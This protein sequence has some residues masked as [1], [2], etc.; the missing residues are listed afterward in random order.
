MSRSI[1]IGGDKGKTG[2][3]GGGSCHA[4]GDESHAANDVS[5][6]ETGG[7]GSLADIFPP[8]DEG[9]QGSQI[10]QNGQGVFGNRAVSVDNLPD[11]GCRRCKQSNANHSQRHHHRTGYILGRV[12]PHIEHESPVAETK[13]SHQQ[14]YGTKKNTDSIIH[15]YLLLSFLPL[16]VAF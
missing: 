1:G 4:S 2:G 7:S 12:R 15:N 13:Q 5:G 6:N 11:N 14:R 10:T 16:T 8:V 3:G 9:Q